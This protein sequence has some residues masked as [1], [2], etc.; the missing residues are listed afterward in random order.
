MASL[1]AGRAGEVR[2][3]S[4][5]LGWGGHVVRAWTLQAFYF[6]F[7]NDLFVGCAGSGC[8]GWGLLSSCGGQAPCGGGSSGC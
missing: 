8:G 2:E 5:R 4:G 6:T 3:E 1:S 7:N